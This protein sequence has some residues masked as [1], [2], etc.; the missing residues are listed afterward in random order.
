METPS[1]LTSWD[2][3]MMWATVGFIVIGILILL[4]HEFRVLQVKDYKEKYDYVNTHEIRY[5]WYAVV[6]FVIAV[7]FY[8]NSLGTDIIISKGMR[9]FYVRLFITASF[10]VIAYFIFY[11]LVRIYYPRYLEKRLT[12][13]R[14]TPRISPAGNAMRKLHEHEEDAHLDASQI[15]EEANVHSVDYDVWLDDKTG[16]KKVEKYDAYLHAI[17][18]T[19]CGYFTMKIH[20]EEIEKKPTVT[21]AGILIKHY[22]C[23]YCKHREAVEVVLAKFSDNV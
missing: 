23:S 22:R 1:F 4:Y 16:F 3:Y 9:W 7:A 13:L 21:E 2:Q 6:A 14:N 18:C 11:S 10:L 17:E 19:E 5:F 20:S 12:K 15:A 8:A